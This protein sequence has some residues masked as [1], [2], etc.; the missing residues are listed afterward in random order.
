MPGAPTAPNGR[1][2]VG[3][4]GTDHPEPTMREVAGAVAE[5]L[6]LC[7]P[8]LS[9]LVVHTAT[10]S[11]ELGWA[12]EAAAEA[13]TESTAEATTRAAPATVRDGT[14]PQPGDGHASATGCAPTVG[15]FYEAPAP[16]ATPFV[17]VG[18]PVLA[19]Q[20]LA[21]VEAMK[22]M[23]P[24]EAEVGGVLVEV[25]KQDGDAVEYGDPLFTLALPGRPGDG[26]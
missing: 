14:P 4:V 15:V 10:L 2:T 13:T 16:G 19:G 22:L 6:R 20:Q 12:T 3:A 18:D 9:R 11:V 17:S 25:H 26:G 5:L 21:I 7:G 1:A 23:I 8:R 24:G